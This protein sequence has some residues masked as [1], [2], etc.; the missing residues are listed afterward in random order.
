[1]NDDLRT[2]LTGWYQLWSRG[3]IT[4]AEIEDALSLLNDLDIEET[5]E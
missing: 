5:D 3:P 4:H 2:W 1:M